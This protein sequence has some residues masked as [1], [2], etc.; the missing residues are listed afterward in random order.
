[1]SSQSLS[2][3][4]DGAPPELKLALV[5]AMAKNRVIGRGGMLPWR[6]PSDLKQF[7]RLTLDKPVIMGRR[8]FVSIGRPLPRR[9]N[10]VITRDPAFHAE[11]VVV[12]ATI[13]DAVEAARVAARELGAGEIMVIGGGEIYRALL[14][15]A[16][17]IY[18]T[19]V[20]ATP[21][22]D[23]IFPAL[24]PDWHEVRREPIPRLDED[25]HDATLL[26][27]DRVT[28]P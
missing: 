16:D 15:T 14:A 18:L 8:T 22:G 20:D 23:T 26:V 11:G 17:R 6:M 13:E 9:H 5:V 27:Y 25:D 7:R 10:I 4:V 28:L 2:T 1:M 19:V 3:G 21:E 12:S 24:G